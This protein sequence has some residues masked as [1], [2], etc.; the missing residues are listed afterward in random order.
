[1]VFWAAT[2][3]GASVLRAGPFAAVW[4]IA[5]IL[6]VAFFRAVKFSTASMPMQRASARANGIGR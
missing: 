2:A 1:M 4:G 5:V 6:A 3:S